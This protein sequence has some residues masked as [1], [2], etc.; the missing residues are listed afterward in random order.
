MSLPGRFLIAGLLT[1]LA[2]FHGAAFLPV[3]QGGQPPPSRVVVDMAGREVPVPAGLRKVVTLGSAPVLNSFVFALGKGETLA[4]GLPANV[5]VARKDRCSFR[6]DCCWFQT[7]FAPALAWQPPL[8]GA[9]WSIKKEA[10][11]SM[12]PDLVIT[13]NRHH[14]DFIEKTAI[15][16]IY[17]DLS[18]RGD[19]NREIMTVLGRAYGTEEKADEYRRYFDS[20]IRRVNA[21]VA[22]VPETQRTRVLYCNFEVMTQSSLTA[23][24]WIEEA[25]GVSVTKSGKQPGHA[26]AISPE[27]ILAWDPDVWIVSVPREIEMV[28]RDARF[29]TIKAVRNKRIFSVPV[30]SIRWSHPTSE[31]PLGVLWAAKLLYPERFKDLSIEEEMKYFYGT[32]FQYHLTDGQ[33]RE[34]LT[35][36]KPGKFSP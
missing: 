22:D 31:Q 8:E 10:L 26:F 25:G 24:W 17:I 35:G 23:D 15:P 9:D 32:F 2:V 36:K 3:A 1:L 18:A 7:V 16:V 19:T 20:V 33:V 13:G 27:Y 34:M 4:N 12:R 29:K 30:G 14:V 5:R 28:F 21:R 11:L 6:D